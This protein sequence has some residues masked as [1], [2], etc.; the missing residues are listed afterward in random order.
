MLHKS[1]PDRD[2]ITSVLRQAAAVLA[3]SGVEVPVCD[4]LP[5][6][7]YKIVGEAGALLHLLRLPTAGGSKRWRVE[8]DEAGNVLD[9]VP[10]STSD[11]KRLRRTAASRGWE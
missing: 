8:L 9:V 10:I 5:T 6:L 7:T 1:A 11:R 2:A 3:V 4:G